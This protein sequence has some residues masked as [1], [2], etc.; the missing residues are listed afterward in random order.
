MFKLSEEQAA[1]ILVSL[2]KDMGEEKISSAGKI[3]FFG[4]RILKSPEGKA[5]LIP[6]RDMIKATYREASVAETMVETSQ[7]AMAEAAYRTAV[8][9]GGKNQQTLTVGWE[10]LGLDKETATRIFEGE[11]KE[12]FISEREKMYGGQTRKYDKKGNVIDKEGHLVDP[13]N[14]VE[15]SDDNDTTT[16]NVYECSDCG[17]TIFVARGRESKF[18]GEGFKCPECGAAKA[19]FKPKDIEED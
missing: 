16:S 5:A 18:Y 9:S 11:A 12:G 17:Y 10:V 2:C 8:I 4:S 6:I 1:R 15:G 19:K 3:L 13:E 7:Q 14:A